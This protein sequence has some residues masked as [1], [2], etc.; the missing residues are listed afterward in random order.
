MRNTILAA[1]L[2][3]LGCSSLVGCKSMPTMSWWKTADKGSPE[4]TALAH[5]APTK[6]SEL[7]KQAEGLAASQV[8]NRGGE[9]VPFVPGASAAVNSVAS[10]TKTPAAYPSTEAPSFSPAQTTTVAAAPL[11]SNAN[12]GSVQMPYDPN[13]VPPSTVA[14]STSPTVPAAGADRYASSAST[15]PSTPPVSSYSNVA[16]PPKTAS[17]YGD[18]LSSL[19]SAAGSSTTGTQVANTGPAA[20]STFPSGGSDSIG[21]TSDVAQSAAEAINQGDRYAQAVAAASQATPPAATEE[22]AGT[23]S[24]EVSGTQEVASAEPYRP[25]GTSTYPGA[26]TAAPTLEVASRPAPPAGTN[27]HIPSIG[28]PNYGQQAPLQSSPQVPSYR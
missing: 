26:S 11:A 2:A 22:I 25:G 21:P 20:G 24:I 28:T 5:S 16:E 1:S 14:T 3:I 8:A 15:P 18:Y 10:A 27:P 23:P 7:A 17:R 6:P 9:A 19:N 13:A 4:S 12:L